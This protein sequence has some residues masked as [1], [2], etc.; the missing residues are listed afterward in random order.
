MITGIL[1]PSSGDAKVYGNWI[2]DDI[3]SVRQSLGLCQQ[4]DV[5]FDDLTVEEHLALVCNLKDIEV[6]QMKIDIQ[7]TL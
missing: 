2:K 5:L 1:S 3:D 7:E 4:F 6:N